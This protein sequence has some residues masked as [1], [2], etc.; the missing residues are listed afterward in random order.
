MGYF[1]TLGRALVGKRM[2]AYDAASTSRRLAT[3]VATGEHLNSLLTYSG[4]TIRARSRDS[5]R[6]NAWMAAGIDDWVNEAIGT[7]GIP[8]PQHSSPEKR[9]RLTE[10]WKRFV[11]EAD[12]AGSCNLYGL[13]ALAFRGV[14]EGGET[15]TR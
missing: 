1:K 6:Q 7:G 10:L 12:A 13:Q 3:W 5:V 14:L 4:D 9:A 15:F 8:H 11:D 2:S